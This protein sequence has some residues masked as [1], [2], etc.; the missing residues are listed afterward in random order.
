MIYKKQ[1]TLKL[2]IMKTLNNIMNVGNPNFAWAIE[3]AYGKID[4]ASSGFKE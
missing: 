1:N 2:S 4:T 3:F